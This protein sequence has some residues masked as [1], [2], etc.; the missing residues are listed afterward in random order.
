MSV[1]DRV[2][3]AIFWGQAGRLIEVALFFVFSLLL[4]RS[5]GPASYGL[6]AQGMSLAGVCAFLAL[7][8][9]G[10]ETLGR[11]LPE[12]VARNGRGYAGRLLMKLL[13]IRGLAILAMAGTVFLFREELSRRFHF[14]LYSGFL[15][16]VL[17]LFAAR[18]ILDLLTYFSSGLL[19][20]RR[21]AAA[22]L[23][24]SLAAPCVFLVFW[25]RHSAT[26]SAAW[27][28][29]A[30]GALAGI[31][32]LAIPFFACRSASPGVIEFSVRRIFA[33][34][35]FAWAT[36]FFIFILGDNTDVLLLGCD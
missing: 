4:A 16:L 18:S 27:L 3:R 23:A 28:A 15:A 26:P 17:F 20:L 14:P 5:L 13:A 30:A 35:M 24:A 32:V 1:A 7:L 12:M 34:G 22:K 31:L 29:T 36:N 25:L 9:L 2:G 10:P 11:F 8:G 33:Y 19:D 21:V 6:Y